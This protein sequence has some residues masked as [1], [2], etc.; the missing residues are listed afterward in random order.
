LVEAL[1][2]VTFDQELAGG[3]L[4][5]L[6]LS[7]HLSGK[8]N[9]LLG[10]KMPRKGEVL[11]ADEKTIA[12]LVGFA[13]EKGNPVLGEA[14]AVSCM[15]CHRIGSQGGLIGPD[16]TSLGTT[17][18]PERIVEELL[19]PNRQ[20]KE[21]YSLVQI[22]TNGGEVLQG[23]ERSGRPGEITI[24]ELSGDSFITLNEKEVASVR[25]LGSAM[26]SNLTAGLSRQRLLNLIQYLVLLGKNKDNVRD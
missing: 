19:W 8:L 14:E 1:K 20:V 16:L 11:S 2:Q 18:S 25:K 13:R 3:L 21:G 17:L 23:Y 7:G 6:Y 12:K 24:R 26:P 4:E 10:A 22:T 5:A 15:G 9:E